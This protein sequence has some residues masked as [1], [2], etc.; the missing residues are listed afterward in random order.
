M[1]IGIVLAA[2]I[3][4]SDHQMKMSYLL[5][6]CLAVWNFSEPM[7]RYSGGQAY[8][9]KGVRH[10]EWLHNTAYNSLKIWKEEATRDAYDMAY[11]MKKQNPH[12]TQPIEVAACVKAMSVIIV[13]ERKKSS[14]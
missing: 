10:Y 9:L 13:E 11:E 8:N 6:E 14:L 3:A 1:M 7:T 12:P 2:G 4:V 5:G